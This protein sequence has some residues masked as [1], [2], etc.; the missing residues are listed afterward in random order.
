M[1]V[2]KVNNPVHILGPG[3]KSPEERTI[4]YLEEVAVECAR[5]IVNKKI[6][7]RKEKGM[8]QSKTWNSCWSLTFIK[9]F[10]TL[11]KHKYKLWKCKYTFSL[12]IQDYVMGFGFV[13]NQIYN[14]VHG[15][16][17]KQSK[18]LYPAPLKIIDV[19]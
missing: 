13:R 10:N 12:E 3:L 8:M 2:L 17:M 14:T 11:F 7:L 5:G 19:S 18:G 6:I 15:K 1:F 9:S 16:V 4:D